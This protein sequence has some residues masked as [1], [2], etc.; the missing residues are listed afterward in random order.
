MGIEL[1]DGSMEKKKQL[2]F[3]YFVAFCVNRSL[4]YGVAA[5]MAKTL[6]RSRLTHRVKDTIGLIAGISNEPM[7]DW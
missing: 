6:H 5:R 3:L 4:N 2:H 1:A 7:L